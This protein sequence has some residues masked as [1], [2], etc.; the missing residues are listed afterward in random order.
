MLWGVDAFF[1]AS[2]VVV[3][4]LLLYGARETLTGL[5]AVSYWMLAP[6]MAVAWILVL[7]IT[8]SRD[9]R[10]AGTGVEEFRRVVTASLYLF[11]GLAIVS[12]L[13]KVSLSRAIFAITL[14][15]GVLALL[16]GRWLARAYLNRL[17]AVGRAVTPSLVVGTGPSVAMLLADMAKRPDVG[18]RAQGVC[19]LSELPSAERPLLGDL[20]QHRLSTLG[21]A[22][23]CGRYGAV[24]VADG[25]TRDQT[26][27]L[28]WSLEAS[29]IELM[30][31]ASLVD[32]AGPRLTVREVEGM[33]LTHV[34]LPSFTGAKLV[35]K[36]VFDVAFSALALIGLAPLLAVVA[37]AI[38]LDDGGPVFFRQQRIGRCGQEFTIHKFR[39][40]SVDAEAKMDALIAEHGGTALLFKLKDDPRITRLGAFLRKYSID[41]LPQFWSVLRGGMSIVGPRPQVAREVAEYTEVH[42]R[43][44]LIKPG[45]TGL[46]QVNGRSEL[47]LE[48][49]IRLD[50]RYVENWS[51]ITDLTIILKTISVVVKPSGAF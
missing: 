20:A 40:M 3:T 35:L 14:P 51:L 18:Y 1:V 32:V 44:L 39:T 16:G 29:P 43:R 12:Y 30:F 33:S 9:F 28:A 23:V 5:D 48:E 45:I 21:D 25:L 46:W 27:N 47:K 2:T 49:S 7:E 10:V 8:D 15:I 31:Q 19:L 34:D 41:E 22:A 37:V 38:K 42:H 6:M 24:I 50:L 26:R 13:A 4:F 11:G 17:R 36:R